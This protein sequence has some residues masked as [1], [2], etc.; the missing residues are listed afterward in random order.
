MGYL[1][2][3]TAIELESAAADG[4]L[5]LPADGRR[6]HVHYTHV[7][8]KG[9][10]DVQPDQLSRAEFWR[11]LARCYREAY[12][13]ADSETG[14][15]LKFGIVCKEK[16]K[17]AKRDVDRSEHHHAAVLGVSGCEAGHRLTVTGWGYEPLFCFSQRA[18][19]AKMFRWCRKKKNELADW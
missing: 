14:S 10:S 6:F 4:L 12:P 8:T 5:M 16:H 9:A 15:I 2:G 13:K 1:A 19:A 3:L 11:H 18:I 7:R 17:D